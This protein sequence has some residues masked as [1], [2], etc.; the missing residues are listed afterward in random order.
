M[1]RHKLDV[2]FV[3]TAD[4]HN[5]EYIAEH[6]KTREWFSGFRGSAGTLVVSAD[7]AALW[8]DSRYFL[9]AA[10][11]LSGTGIELMKDGLAETPDIVEWISTHCSIS[12]AN[13]TVGL[14]YATCGT[15]QYCADFSNFATKDV[16]LA[17][18]IWKDRPALPKRPI[19]RHPAEWTSKT[20]GEKIELVRRLQHELIAKKLKA[21]D[22]IAADS[23]R[24][25]DE[26]A[27]TYFL[28]NDISEI[29]WL[30]NSTPS[31]FPIYWWAN[32][33]L[34]FSLISKLSMKSC[35]KNWNRTISGSIPTKVQPISFVRS[36][37]KKTSSDM[38]KA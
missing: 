37:R 10:E 14:D 8:T 22:P 23:A 16:D 19:V 32:A 7:K 28:Y 2:Y 25:F 30:L 15:G 18:E 17:D 27:E 26:S 36:I 38:P 4:P 34:T 5:S 1:K 29:A 35:E 13:F 33:T 12:S 11:E 31:S 21:A 20:A 3:P 24:N 9:Q 6:W